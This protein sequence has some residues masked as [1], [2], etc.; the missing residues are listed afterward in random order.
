MFWCS[1]AP[2][3]GLPLAAAA[4]VA[5]AGVRGGPLE[6]LPALN[7]HRYGPLGRQRRSHSSTAS[8]SSAA[9]EGGR[10][11]RPHDLPALRRAGDFFRTAARSYATRRRRQGL[12]NVQRG[13][14]TILHRTQVI[15]GR[16]T[17]VAFAALAPLR[18]R[19]GSALGQRRRGSM[20]SPVRRRLG[21]G[22]VLSRPLQ[23]VRRHQPEVLLADFLQSHWR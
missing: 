6:L 4:A 2:S 16:G 3:G 9:R 5:R 18:R 11:D 12:A 7:D 10:R 20:Q 15:G 13:T 14:R 17:L 1:S 23:Q 22:Q 21:S 8:K 19:L